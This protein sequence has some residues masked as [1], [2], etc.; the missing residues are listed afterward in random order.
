MIDWDKNDS[1]IYPFSLI[2]K[3]DKALECGYNKKQRRIFGGIQSMVFPEDQRQRL[4]E[5]ENKIFKGC[6]PQSC[7]GVPGGLCGDNPHPDFDLDRGEGGWIFWDTFFHS[8]ADF[9][10]GQRHGFHV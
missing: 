4:R 1:Y 9:R 8:S 5:V 3:L 10:G 6:F 2:P 7:V